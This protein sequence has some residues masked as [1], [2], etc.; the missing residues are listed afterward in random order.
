[1]FNTGHNYNPCIVVKIFQQKN[2]I[3]DTTKGEAE[4]AS[5]KGT[6]S[7]NEAVLNEF[8]RGPFVTYFGKS[9]K[10]QPIEGCSS[11]T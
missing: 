9:S 7:N 4:N 10:G 5:S 1:M 11:I 2:K 8:L 3:I 6:D